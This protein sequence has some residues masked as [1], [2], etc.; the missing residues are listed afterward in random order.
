MY[1]WGLPC[2]LLDQWHQHILHDACQ[3]SGSAAQLPCMPHAEHQPSDAC[4]VLTPQVHRGAPLGGDAPGAGD[5]EEGAGRR[6]AALAPGRPG[7]L[8]PPGAG[9]T[10]QTSRATVSWLHW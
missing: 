7:A 9:A 4:L 5:D 3:Q 1:S 6:G 2:H 8:Q 10:G